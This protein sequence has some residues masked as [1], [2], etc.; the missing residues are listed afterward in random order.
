MYIE[1]REMAVSNLIERESFHTP[2][3]VEEVLRFLSPVSG[4]IYLDCTLGTGGHAEAIL[5]ASDPDGVV[6]G[7]DMDE[8]ALSVA[9]MRLSRFGG[10]FK[11]IYGNFKDAEGLIRGMNIEGVNGILLDL[12]IS[13]LQLEDSTRGFSFM[14]EGPLDMR[15]DKETPVTAEKIINTWQIEKIERILKEYGEE[16]FARRIAK[17]I[18][19]YREKNRISTTSELREIIHSAVPS[20]VRIRHRIDPAT[21][22]FQALRIAVNSELENLRSF[23]SSALNLMVRGGRL[24][25]ISYHSLEDRIV[26]NKF[27]E[28]KASGLFE[29][30]TPKVVTPSETEKTDNPRSRSAKLRAGE[31]IK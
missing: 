13:S 10:R 1:N 23:L 28:W 18:G 21:K 16:R 2:V 5:K 9:E 15:M 29:I 7:I 27:R 17:R 3:M 19:E 26:K 24:V 11:C 20:W 31:K 12:G 14:K 6:I 22:S 4:G 25:I 30:L 8:K